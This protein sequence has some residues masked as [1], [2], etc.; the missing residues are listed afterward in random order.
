M[1]ESSPP[2]FETIDPS[3]TCGG[4][5]SLH[6]APL[7][8]YLSPRR[9]VPRIIPIDVLSGEA[10]DRPT[11]MRRSN[12]ARSRSRRSC[13]RN[14]APLLDCSLARIGHHYKKKILRKQTALD[15]HTDDG[16]GA[17]VNSRAR[18]LCKCFFFIYFKIS[19]LKHELID[20]TLAPFQGL[21]ELQVKN[22]FFPPLIT[23]KDSRQLFAQFLLNRSAKPRQLFRLS[24]VVG[25]AHRRQGL[26]F[27]YPYVYMYTHAS[28]AAIE[29]RSR[30]SSRLPR[31]TY[32]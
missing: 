32:I 27:T 31:R 17:T 5:R 13:R 24:E 7:P 26:M 21:E 3:T 9:L 1:D 8:M 20:V 29:R 30:G 10:N 12:F 14:A 22:Q 19:A 25:N 16:S 11:R 28:E 4:V 23:T 15:A 2:E 6:S 18:R